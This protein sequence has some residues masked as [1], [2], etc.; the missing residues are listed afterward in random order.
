MIKVLIVEDDPMVAELNRRYLEQIDGF[1]LIAMAR[2]VDEALGLLN[3]HDIN[4]VLLDIFM[5]GTSGLELLTQIRDKGKDIDVIVVS[6]ACDMQTI[7]KALRNGAVDYLIKPFEFERLNTALSEYR[8]Q[9][10][11]MRNRDVMSQTELDR[12]ILGREQQ[13]Q[14]ELNK[15]LCRSTLNAVWEN[16]RYAKGQSFTTEEMANSVGISRVSMRKYLDFLK[17]IDI[18]S[19]EVVYGTVGRPVYRYRCINSESTIIKRYL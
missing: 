6:A 10:V 5:P 1:V 19:M 18:L 13:G 17:H 2:T 3:K 16:I 4:L 11:F 8:N 7:K 15:G 9:A 12:R 14:A